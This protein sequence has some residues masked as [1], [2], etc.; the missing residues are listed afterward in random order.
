MRRLGRLSRRAFGQSLG[1]SLAL[2]MLPRP[3]PASDAPRVVEVRIS[4]FAFNPER[5]EIATGD[6]IVWINEDLAP[7]TATATDGD[8]DTGAIRKGKEARVTFESQGAFEYFCAFH[9]HMT[10]TVTVRPRHGG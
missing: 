5:V 4:D 1:A 10:G 6:T 8:W 9:P 2:A 3:V 7:H